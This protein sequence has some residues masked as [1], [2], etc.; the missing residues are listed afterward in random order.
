MLGRVEVGEGD[1]DP[2]FDFTYRDHRCA[3]ERRRRRGVSVPR[4]C[5]EF[6]C[7]QTI[8]VG[9]RR[10]PAQCF[11]R[12]VT[13]FTLTQPIRGTGRPAAVA[14]SGVITMPNRRITVRCA[15]RSVPHADESRQPLGKEPRSRM[16]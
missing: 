7:V 6:G 13:P 16:S 4:R 3:G 9:S 5:D 11:L 2:D 8:F 10:P 1:A 14:R 15:T 12:I